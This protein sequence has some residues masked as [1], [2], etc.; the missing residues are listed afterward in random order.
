MRAR[1]W[2]HRARDTT[3]LWVY[4]RRPIF[5]SGLKRRDT[6]PPVT[7]K[8]DWQ[9]TRKLQHRSRALIMWGNGITRRAFGSSPVSRDLDSRASPPSPARPPSVA[10]LTSL[11]LLPIPFCY[12]R[13]SFSMSSAAPQR[14]C[15]VT[16]LQLL[17]RSSIGASPGAGILVTQATEDWNVAARSSQATHFAQI[18]LAPFRS[19]FS[20]GQISSRSSSVAL[21]SILTGDG[22]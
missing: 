6:K 16:Y 2:A 5:Y 4:K 20:S 11:P 10:L 9:I 8:R 15:F 3:G 18:S 19:F 14:W 1:P 17:R 22:G 12:H 21:N 13:D 7:L